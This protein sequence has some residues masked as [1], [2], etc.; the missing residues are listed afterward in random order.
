MQYWR[1]RPRK[2]VD[3]SS[4]HRREKQ[5]WIHR[6]LR[7]NLV[8]SFWASLWLRLSLAHIQGMGSQL[9]CISDPNLFLFIMSGH[10]LLLCCLKYTV[11][12]WTLTFSLQEDDLDFVHGLP[13]QQAASCFWTSDRPWAA[14]LPP[15][16]GEIHEVKHENH[17]QGVINASIDLRG[18]SLC[19]Y[20]CRYIRLT[21]SS[22]RTWFGSLKLTSFESIVL[23]IQQRDKPDPFAL[24]V[25]AYR[26]SLWGKR[27]K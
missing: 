8:K 26:V 23:D 9:T 12:P 14:N 3:I 13:N 15:T 2:P 21:A 24:F 20:L 11:C 7:Q 4:P 1:A 25:L 17:V 18:H 27:S 22:R 19:G 16:F 5:V 6:G 10:Q